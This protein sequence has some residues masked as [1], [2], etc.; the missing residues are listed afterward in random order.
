MT[1]LK[2]ILT[3]LRRHRIRT[4]IGIAGISFGVAA[5]LS[6]MTVLQGAI[7]MFE[8]ILNTD[9]E[10]I[11][12]EK[13]V[14]D[15]FFSNVPTSDIQEMNN[16]AMVLH[17]DP[18]LFGIVSTPGNPVVTCFGVS[19]EDSR[20]RS[21]EWLQGS[22]DNF[23]KNLEEVTVGTRAAQ[24]LKG[25]YRGAVEIGKEKFTV[26]AVIR[27]SNG[28]EDGGVFMPLQTAQKFFHKDGFASV[29]TVK[30]RTKEARSEFKRQ[31]E[32]RFPSLLALENQE[33]SRSYSQFKILKT[34]AWAVG[35]CA[36][37]LGGLSVANTMIMSVFTRIR[38][39]AVLRVCGFS[40]TQVSALII[41]ESLLVALA[42]VLLGICLSKGGLSV[43]KSL[44]LLQGYVDPQLHYAVIAQV[45]ILAC[46][47]GLLGAAYPAIYGARI[48]AAQALRFE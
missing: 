16:W 22:R 11:V 46:I 45:A 10:V 1:F 4:L 14:S 36:F 31:V 44:P 43:L 25:S 19:A 7:R 40:R 32:R 29:A 39:I 15:L 37:L 18:V 28:F 9:S 27:A 47:T 34:T 30:L 24:F 20:L 17:A 2:L 23:G 48:Q 5:M 13:N 12:F 38:E 3:N 33:F 21:A 42:G 8:R 26:G 41:G 6:V 35:G